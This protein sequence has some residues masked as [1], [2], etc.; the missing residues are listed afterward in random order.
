MAPPTIG[1]DTLYNNWK[2]ELN[3]WED[4]IG[5]PEEKRA[6]AIFMNLTRE[7]KEAVSNMQINELT[8]KNG[9][10]NLI[11]VLDQMYLK[12]KSAQAYEANEIF[13]K[14]ARPHNMI[15]Y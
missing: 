12:D 14:F 10:E 8:D 4:F 9:V 6:P 3:I 15:I 13:G 7:A 11:A 5:F 1:K 2:K